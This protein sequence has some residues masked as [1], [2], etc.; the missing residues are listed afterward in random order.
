MKILFI[1]PMPPP[2][3]LILQKITYHYGIG[4]ISAVLKENG[5]TTDYLALNKLDKKKLVKKIQSFQ[6]DLIGITVTSNQFGLSQEISSFIFETFNLPIV[7][8][9]VHPTVR[10]EESINVKGI[11]GICIGEGEFPMLEL[12]NAMSQNDGL[13]EDNLKIG[14]FWFNVDG[15]VLKNPMRA[16]VQDL[17]SLPFCD[18]E[19]IDFQHLLNYHKYLE[20]RGS[21]GCPYKCAFCVNATYQG[22]YKNH[23]KFYRTRSA[24]NLLAEIES[25]VSRY[26]NIRTIVFDDELM[27]VN[28]KWTLDLLDKYKQK[29]NFPFNLTIRANLVDAEFVKAL[30]DAGCNTLMMGVENGDDHIRNEVLNKG[31]SSE[32][33]IEAGRLIK[34]AG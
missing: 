20:V 32:Q 5:H 14:N 9:G 12:V 8:G 23:G 13:N 17:D 24:E 16:L 11:L 33:I 34:E 2:S 1:H 15:R 25:L 22:I 30:K 3:I 19:I 18:R 27:S 28:K 10:P 6:P 31:I 29:F 7:L 21:R 26:K 4:S